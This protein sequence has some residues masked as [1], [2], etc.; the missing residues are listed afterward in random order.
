MKTGCYFNAIKVRFIAKCLNLGV[1]YVVW[2]CLHVQHEDYCFRLL[3]PAIQNYAT[4]V[5]NT[6]FSVWHSFFE[7]S[8]YTIRKYHVG[9]SSSDIFAHICRLC[10]DGYDGYEVFFS[11]KRKERWICLIISPVY[12]YQVLSPYPCRHIG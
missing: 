1:R 12:L 9:S 2:G 11:R 10:V 7:L 4:L 3:Q 8:L 6:K 5:Y